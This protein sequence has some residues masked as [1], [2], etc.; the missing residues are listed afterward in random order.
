[1]RDENFE[2]GWTPLIAGYAFGALFGELFRR[3]DVA[4]AVALGSLERRGVGDYVSKWFLWLA[5]VV[6][7]GATISAIWLL[8]HPPRNVP[9]LLLFPRSQQWFVAALLGVM[10]VVAATSWIGMR[11]LAQSPVPAAAPDRQ[12]VHHAIR[13]AAI[14]SVAGGAVM[15]IG[16][17]GSRLGFEAMR[18][19]GNEAD[20]VQWILGLSTIVCVVAVW[21]GALLTV[22]AVPRLAPFAGRL[23][24]VPTAN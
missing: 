8:L 24:N 4:G 20:S 19:D 15:A 17:I 14:L 12:A 10:V 3:R 2:F 7:L 1:M 13:T 18:I 22:T 9:S 21:F 5:V 6:S 11:R 23:P 16:G